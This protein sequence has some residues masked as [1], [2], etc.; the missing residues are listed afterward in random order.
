MNL[1]LLTFTVLSQ[2]L[3]LLQPCHSTDVP[4]VNCANQQNVK[5]MRPYYCKLEN[6]HVTQTAPKFIPIAAQPNNISVVDIYES[7]LP[8]FTASGI[9]E[10]FP[11]LN[12]I[13][14]NSLQ[15]EKVENDAFSQC[16]QLTRIRMDNNTI[17]S[18]DAETFANLVQLKELYF[19]GNNLT[20][21]EAE[22]FKDLRELT[23]LWLCHNNFLNLNA[24]KMIEYMPT[25]KKI[26]LQDNLIRCDRMAK[27]IEI[28]KNSSVTVDAFNDESYVKSRNFTMSEVQ[29]FKCLKPDQ[30]ELVI[31]DYLKSGFVTP[32]QVQIIKSLNGVTKIE[33]VPGT[34]K[35][36]SGLNT[37]VHNLE[38]ENLELMK[39]FNDLKTK[40]NGKDTNC[41]CPSETTNTKTRGMEDRPVNR[42]RN[43]TLNPNKVPEGGCLVADDLY[44]K[45]DAQEMKLV[46]LEKKLGD[47]LTNIQNMLKNRF[48]GRVEAKK[49]EKE[50]TN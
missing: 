47:K 5:E 23:E 43:I 29:G 24:E 3:Q 28:F 21:I 19:F 49:D 10:A 2:I 40:M 9:C 36:I 33:V 37:K 46:E 25:L 32:E 31:N 27:I 6:I 34:A 30:Y 42:P 12:R 22:A 18:I 7:T 1:I 45:L 39:K 20:F 13:F 16:H 15:I 26:L 38:E 4:K 8:V 11:N 41:T 50:T 14:V 17:K 44:A 35:N 48:K